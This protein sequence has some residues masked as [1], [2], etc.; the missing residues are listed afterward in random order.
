MKAFSNFVN[1]K[2]VEAAD[3]QTLDVVNPVTGEKYATAPL[4]G[5]A[6]VDAAM[7]AAA[8]AFPGWRDT[9]PSQRSL[10]LFRIADAIEARADELIAAEVENTGKP[11]ALTASEEMPPM[12][13][14]IRFFAGRGAPPRGQERRRV[15][16]EHDLVGAPR[17]RRR[18]RPGRPV[19]LPVDDGRVEVRPGDRRRQH[20]RPQA[21]RHDACEHHARRRDRR[22]VPAARRAQ[23]DLR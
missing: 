6:D 15:H 16:G 23:R 2:P 7:A 18:V 5:P 3:G 11:I 22:R 12:I 17:A 13:D 14:Q 10:A 9:T 20:R 4:S 8:E 19:E 1:G 21:E